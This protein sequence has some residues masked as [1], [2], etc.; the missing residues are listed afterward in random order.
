MEY[1]VLGP[2][3]VLADGHPLKL[4]GVKQ[5]ALLAILLLRANEVVAR[6]VLVDELWGEKPPSD[7]AHSLDVQVSRLRKAL[8]AG[9]GE[10][11]LL[12]RRGG[13]VLRVAS[14]AL[15]LSRFESLLAEGERASSPRRRSGPRRSFARR[16]SSGAGRPSGTSCMNHSRPS[17][18]T[19]SRSSA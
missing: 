13:Y 9:T 12:T 18:P 6:D 17:R 16:S 14:D 2:L 5:R 7:A 15:D 10:R 19:G 4:G 11:M 3:E 8:E 1:R